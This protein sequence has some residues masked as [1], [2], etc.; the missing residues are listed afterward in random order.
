[1]LKAEKK[2]KEAIE[3]AKS[4]LA[5]LKELLKINDQTLA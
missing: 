1:L 4:S 3:N 2:N 5:K